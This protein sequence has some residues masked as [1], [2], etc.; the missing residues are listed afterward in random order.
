LILDSGVPFLSIL[1]GYSG[2]LA[3]WPLQEASGTVAVA[4]NVAVALGRNIALQTYADYTPDG[5]EW[6]NPSGEIARC[7]GSQAHTAC[8]I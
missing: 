2:Y 1:Q 7:D 8:A 5:A 6:S 3:A 4:D